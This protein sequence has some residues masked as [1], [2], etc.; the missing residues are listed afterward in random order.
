MTK[1]AEF[2]R[3]SKEQLAEFLDKYTVLDNTPW[4]DWFKKKYCDNCESI[5]LTR[6]EY[7]KIFG[8]SGYS[9]FVDCAY[10]E[11]HRGCK[12]FPDSEDIPDVKDMILLW[13]ESN[14]D[15]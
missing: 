10:C 8:C 5:R 2:L 9:S 3:M 15:D 14:T 13:L 7:R 12:F 4:G 6:E 1:Y 11:L